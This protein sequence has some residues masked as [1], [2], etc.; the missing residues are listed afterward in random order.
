MTLQDLFTSNTIQVLNLLLAFVAVWLTWRFTAPTGH[1]NIRTEK[2]KN[3]IIVALL[4]FM[5]GV[6]LYCIGFNW[7]GSKDNF[8]ALIA[9]SILS[10]VEMFVSHSDLIEVSPEMK[11][12]TIYMTF[13]ALTHFLAVFINLSI[14]FNFIGFQL[15]SAQIIR[16]WL[17]GSV[18]QNL[19]IFVSISESTTPI[20]A[21]I[22]KHE[23]NSWIVWV[24]LNEQSEEGARFSF[25][26]LFSALAYRR[27]LVYAADSVNAILVRASTALEGSATMES[28]NEQM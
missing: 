25:H 10:S 3:Y 26:S 4:I 19:H 17:K 7:E 21:D 20:A 9:R 6:V 16:K 14:L 12:N 22:R 11:E 18:K 27:E 2:T 24:T 15:S 1:D 23:P 5:S 28:Q 13:F 8:V